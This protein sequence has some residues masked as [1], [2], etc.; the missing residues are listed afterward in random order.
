MKP[1]SS[2]RHIT[3]AHHQHCSTMQ[4]RRVSPPS[5]STLPVRAP[6]VNLSGTWATWALCYALPFARLMSS[7]CRTA[8]ERATLANPRSSSD[9]R[10]ECETSGV[11]RQASNAPTP[12]T[13][14]I[15]A[16]IPLRASANAAQATLGIK[17]RVTRVTRGH[18][19]VCLHGLHSRHSTPVINS[20]CFPPAGIS[21]REGV[22][23]GSSF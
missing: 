16:W 8:Y 21:E 5:V 12:D 4:R 11:K 1:I 7:Y 2:R 14:F 20:L 19:D 15:P 10:E 13:V 17:S 22:R 3:I 23:F 18:R 9:A 6:V